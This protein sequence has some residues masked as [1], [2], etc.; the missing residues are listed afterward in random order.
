MGYQKDNLYEVT[1][2]SLNKPLPKWLYAVWN[3]TDSLL[4]GKMHY[5]MNY[6]LIEIS[7]KTINIFLKDNKGKVLETV[8]IDI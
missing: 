2:S 6:G 1:S 8:Q 3:E 4:Q 5:I 7:F